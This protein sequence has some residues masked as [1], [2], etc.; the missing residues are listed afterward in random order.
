LA[1]LWLA[2]PVAL[3]DALVAL[4]LLLPG[5]LTGLLV[6]RGYRP[7]PLARAMLRRFRGANALF[8][9]LVAG[10]VAL[11]AGLVAQERALRQGSARAAERFD[12]VLGAP[13]SEVSL[14]LAAVYLQPMDL[15]LLSGEVFAEVAADPEVDLAA[16][17]AF[18]DSW[19]GAPVVGTTAE[20][21]A[22]LAGDLAE[23]RMFASHAEA[24]AGAFA[25]VA[26]GQA[27]EPAHGQG[28]MAEDHAHGGSAYAVVGRMAPTGSPWD[29]ALLVP[30]EAV[31]EVHALPT[32]HAPERAERIGPPFDPEWF[33]GTPAILVRADAVWANY[34]L[35][36][37]YTRADVMGVFPGAVLAGLHGLLRDLR[38][39]MSLMALVTQG[40]VVVAV[41][42]GLGLLVRVFARG[43]ALLRA[44]GAPGRFVLAV[45]WSY[46]ATLLGLGATLGLA[47]GWAV[48]ALL[49]RLVTARTDVLVTASPG[50]TE[51]HLVTG[52][53]SA[54]LLLA[55]L[56]ALL[57][58]QQ[59]PLEDLRR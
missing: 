35:R 17:I 48:A 1:D 3:Q 9:G 56:P 34:A 49:S 47:L 4:G 31:W 28:E 25:P 7:W 59:P 2:L 52:F 54:A 23:G 37:R 58:R 19:N 33:P 55:L 15:P 41:L 21:V 8:V 44:L 10:A 26:L 32:G 29:R 45:V 30:V 18:G 6:V 11:G 46:A 5:L 12:L 38:E 53:A 43:L 42:A 13:G 24:V 14:V 27:V 57:A 16:P 51:V 50:W 20:F 36:D 40:L 39:A 22:H